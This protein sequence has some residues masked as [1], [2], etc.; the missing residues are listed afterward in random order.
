MVGVIMEKPQLGQG[1]YRCPK[2]GC[3][4]SEVEIIDP[5][6]RHPIGAEGK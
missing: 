1:A 4:S 3:G 6:Y 5:N 2:A